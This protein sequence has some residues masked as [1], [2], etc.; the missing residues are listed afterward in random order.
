MIPAI[1]IL[2]VT[3]K[4]VNGEIATEIKLLRSILVRDSAFFL[5]AEL[6]LLIFLGFDSLKWWMGLI[7]MLTYFAYAF[8][9]LSTGNF[10]EDD[11]AFADLFFRINP[12]RSL[13]K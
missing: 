6:L 2:A 8:V 5:L 10:E 11:E 9:L 7:L 4:G 1:C 12:R 3:V 13:K